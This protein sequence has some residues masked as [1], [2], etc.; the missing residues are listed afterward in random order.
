MTELLHPM[1][2]ESFQRE[3]AVPQGLLDDLKIYIDLLEK[4][5]KKINL[6]SKSTMNDVWHRHVLDSYQIYDLIPTSARVVADLG[7]GAGFPGLV[8][9]LCSKH[10]GGP[11]VHLVEADSR[12]CA[13]LNEVNNQTD[14]QAEIHTCRIES[15][16]DMRADVV[17]ARAL[18][19]LKKLMKLAVRLENGST[20]YIFPK[21]EKAS[22]ELTE[23]AKE[24]TMSVIKTASRTHPAATILTLKGV[25]R[26]A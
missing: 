17:T 20:T 14:A 9:A 21:G 4:W 19:P 24:W 25:S 12:K 23:A 15:L 13:F 1:S 6:V 8:L 5:Q 10:L 11:T 26:R 22:Q 18:A 2:P 3:T 7:S 16:V